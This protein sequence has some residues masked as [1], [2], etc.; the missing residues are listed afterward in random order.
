MC[1]AASMMQNVE[2][3]KGRWAKISWGGAIKSPL[4]PRRTEGGA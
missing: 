2:L 4:N 3:G 1:M